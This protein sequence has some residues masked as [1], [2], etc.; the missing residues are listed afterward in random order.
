MRHLIVIQHGINSWHGNMDNMKKYL[1][2][3]LN[4]NYIIELSNVNNFSKSFDGLKQ[5]G[6][7]LFNFV[8]LFKTTTCRN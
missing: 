1:S 3:F 8:L 7:N 5:C 6:F 2:K 4:R